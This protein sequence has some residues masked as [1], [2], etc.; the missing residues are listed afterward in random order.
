M[1]AKKYHGPKVV[2]VTGGDAAIAS[3]NPK[4]CYLTD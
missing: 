3:E 1:T 4:N 2:G